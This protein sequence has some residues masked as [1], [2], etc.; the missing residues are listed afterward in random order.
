MWCSMTERSLAEQPSLTTPSAPLKP[1]RMAPS[2]F[3]HQEQATRRATLK[4]KAREALIEK[5]LEE[6][7]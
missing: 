5:S 1:T 6:P 3:E 2:Y 7:A 4:R